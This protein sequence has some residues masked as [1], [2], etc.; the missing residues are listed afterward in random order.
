[1]LNLLRSKVRHWRPLHKQ[2]HGLRT[3]QLEERRYGKQPSNSLEVA[4]LIQEI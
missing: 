3:S 1:M 2:R 4:G